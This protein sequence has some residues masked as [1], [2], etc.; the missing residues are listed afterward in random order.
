MELVEFAKEMI[1][2]VVEH[3]AS[4]RIGQATLRHLDRTLW[5]V[6]KC[7]RWAV[8]PPLD[9]DERPPPELLRPLPWVFFLALLVTLRITRES[10][11]LIN[12]VMGKPP[13]RSADVV[14]Y[15]QSKRRYLRTLKYTGSRAMRARVSQP[16]P[17]YTQI[18]SMLELTM[19]FRRQSY[20]G[21]N[22]T[23]SQSNNDEVLVV[24][25][26]KRGREEASPT[27][28]ANETTMERLMEKIMVDLDVESDEDSSYTLTNATS[29][30]SEASDGTVES[31][32]EDV[33]P[34]DMTL[35]IDGDT[36]T[37]QSEVTSKSAGDTRTD[38]NNFSPT[39]NIIVSSTPEKEKDEEDVDEK[40]E[41]GEGGYET[42][43]E[44]ALPP[45]EQQEKLS[46]K[47]ESKSFLDNENE[48][49][50]NQTS[51]KSEQKIAN[52]RAMTYSK[53]KR[54]G[55]NERR[56]ADVSVKKPADRT[57]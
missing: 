15:I 28:S 34:N 40:D 37:E 19:C 42:P 33:S 48:T 49:Q 14:M 4:Y 7:A 53:K 32:Q 1:H 5:V 38:E 24:K 56:N 30:K 20:Y 54:G 51:P 45:P 10:I 6:E 39:K 29:V 17:W 35:K 8:P 11:S 52:G 18:Q 21:N 44:T 31:D 16:R 22:N 43:E 13:L 27:V 47:A 36:L 12:L 57:F 46:P 25:R 50:K 3:F 41:K 23:T 55:K 9:Q 2:S 26:S